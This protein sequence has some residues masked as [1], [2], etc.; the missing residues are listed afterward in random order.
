MCARAVVRASPRR[1]KRCGG[2]GMA[3]RETERWAAGVMTLSAS[4]KS[5]RVTETEEASRT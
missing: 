5:S 4:K 1:G 3:A 2:S